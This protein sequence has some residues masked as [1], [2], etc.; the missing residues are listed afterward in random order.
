M[1][2]PK[3]GEWHFIQVVWNP[4]GSL[5]G[6]AETTVIHPPDCDMV[7]TIGQHGT[8]FDWHC[9]LQYEIDNNGVLDDLGPGWHVARSWVEKMSAGPW[10][11]E[12]TTGVEILPFAPPW[13]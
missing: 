3:L 1:S 13:E 8:M 12:I 2:D 7:I 4:A 10:I 6:E 11:S 5:D 9:G